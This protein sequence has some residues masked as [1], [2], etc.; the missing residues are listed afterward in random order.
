MIPANLI[1]NSN[2]LSEDLYLDT[3]IK[4]LKLLCETRIAKILLEPKIY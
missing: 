1:L 3:N 2:S 4:K